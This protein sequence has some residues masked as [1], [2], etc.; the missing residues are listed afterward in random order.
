MPTIH[1]YGV[2]IE[3][4]HENFIFLDKHLELKTKTNILTNIMYN[5]ECAFVR[6][7]N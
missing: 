1:T 2:W 4:K 6:S 7:L 3:Y 5:W